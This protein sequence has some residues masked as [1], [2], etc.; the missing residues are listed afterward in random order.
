[1]KP[2]RILLNGTL[3]TQDQNRPLAGALAIADGR[4]LAVGESHEIEA[5]AGP[6]TEILDLEGR[7]VL[8]GFMDSH[9]H[10][11]DWALGRRNLDLAGAT[12]FAEFQERLA[13]ASRNTPS[14]AWILG[15]GWNESDWPEDRMPTRDD[16]D[17]LAPT[18][19]V[20]LWRCDLHLAVANSRAL[21][22]AGIDEHTPDPPHGVIVRDASGR[23]NG[24]LRENAPNLV[25]E[26]V[27]DPGDASVFEAMLDGIPEFH[28][29]GLTGLCDVRL[30]GGIEGSPAMRSWQRIHD[31]GKL[32][33]RCWA[34]LPGERMDEAIALG[35]RT[36]F[37]DERLRLGHVKFFM[38]GGMGARTAWMIDPYL[39]AERGM[40]LW[41]L[42][43]L[44]DA[45]FRCDRAG[46]AV[47]IHAIGDRANREVISL[48]ESLQTAHPKGPE[49]EALQ[50]AV[51][52]RPQ[53]QATDQEQGKLPLC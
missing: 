49:W 28:S 14:E 26:V 34:S 41:N 33:L 17:A 4:I 9:I 43:E 47:M 3:R 42:E 48:F 25:K 24:I 18:H 6:G 2:E 20:I 39:D 11:Y 45:I 40:A 8:P 21:Q 16:L 7:L 1:M 29:Y 52:H 13:E 22:L 53:R 23:P 35:L 51:R 36:G 19:P 31:Q 44:R 10:Y 27:S 12:S 50:P 38:D 15:Q 46:L 37:G 30:M 32:D 5:L